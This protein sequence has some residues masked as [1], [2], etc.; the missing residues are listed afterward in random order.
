MENWADVDGRA[1]LR[2]VD[3]A[4]LSLDRALNVVQALL[5]DDHVVTT[6]LEVEEGK[7][8]GFS[9][10]QARSDLLEALGGTAGN[11][12]R[13]G[14]DAATWGALPEHR[15]SLQAA[16]AFAGGAAAPRAGP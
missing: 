13:R 6:T 15:A 1:L 3:L 7:A 9:R 10:A 11:G 8:K 16:M 2:G 14:W 5:V 12:H 4:E